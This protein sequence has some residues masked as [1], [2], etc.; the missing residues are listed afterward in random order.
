MDST[1]NEEIII[2]YD[3]KAQQAN[4]TASK[5]FAQL[6][7]HLDSSG[8]FKTIGKT[9]KP[10][11]INYYDR[12]TISLS[13]VFSDY[14]LYQ[15]ILIFLKSK[16]LVILEEN[17]TLNSEAKTVRISIVLENCSINKP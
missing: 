13:G 5:T 1:F 2:E 3:S 14:M 10:G 6:A 11:T 17:P 7:F 8:L 12:N 15:N 4:V 16:K 9:D